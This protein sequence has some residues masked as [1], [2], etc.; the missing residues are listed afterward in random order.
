MRRVLS[1]DPGNADALNFIGYSYADR[2]IHLDE[3]EQMIVQALKIKPDSGYILDSMGWV[4][5]RKSN[6]ESALTYLKK[7]LE[8]LP[9]DPGVMEHLGDVYFETG[10]R[11]E[12]LEWYRKAIKADP[13]NSRLKN[14]MD[15]LKP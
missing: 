15:L 1:L 13:A 12:A 8:F 5:F 14:K 10:R 4:H 2:G 9:E 6:Y 3:A 7:A 11:Q